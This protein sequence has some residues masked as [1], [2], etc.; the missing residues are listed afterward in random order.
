MSIAAVVVTYN[1]KEL[2]MTCI[3]SILNQTSAEPDVLVIDNASTDGT[4]A[5]I[6]EIYNDNPRV[7]YK[8]T[9]ANIGGAGGF[10]YGI[11]AA[12]NMGYDY[13]WLMDDDT[14]PSETALSELLKAAELY[15]NNFGFLASF[16]KWTDG[17]PCEMNVPTVSPDWRNDISK[18]FEHHLIALES[19]SFV[20]LFIRSEVVKEVGLPIK[21]FFIWADDMEYTLRIS[22]RFPS[23]F[24]YD[25]Q[26]THA[27][28]SNIATSI[29]DET[30]ESRLDRY[31]LLYRNRY[32]IAR[33]TSKRAKILYWLS[34]K[35]T[36]RDINKSTT[37]NKALKRRIVRKSAWSG[38]FFHPEIEMVHPTKE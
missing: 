3:N 19:A 16:V 21:E 33:R 12:V 31:K 32:Y 14:F 1:R 23:Y 28:K 7:I 17:S 26:V 24:V 5:A 38:L 18:Q 22:S 20:S 8:N 11:N 15:N 4:D 36:I 10:S 30:D 13:L 34:V 27:I 35:N 29:I 25:S 2:L 6:A 9:G 37:G